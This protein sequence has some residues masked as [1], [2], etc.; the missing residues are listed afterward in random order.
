M[1]NNIGSGLEPATY[2]SAPLKTL[3]RLVASGTYTHAIQVGTRA[4][5]VMEG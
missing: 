4:V 1:V 5:G 3:V 2:V